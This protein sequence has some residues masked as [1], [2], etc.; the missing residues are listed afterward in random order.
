MLEVFAAGCCMLVFLY[1][2]HWVGA[3]WP[4]RHGWLFVS[5]DQL[6]VDVAWLNALVGLAA[7]VVARVLLAP[8]PAAALAVAAGLGLAAAS[9]RKMQLL[10]MPVLPWDLWFAADA[11]AF[12]GFLGWPLALLWAA[13]GLLALALAAVVWRWPAQL[14]RRRGHAPALLA[15]AGVVLAGNAWVV[16]PGSPRFLSGQVHNIGWDPGANHTNYG[17]FYAF[18]ANLK[19]LDL[20]VPDDAA[21]RAARGIG[22]QL[23]PA[24]AAVGK[25]PADVV[26]VLSE[27]FT[28]LPV[29]LFHQPWRCLDRAPAA[30]LLT[31]SWGGFTAN[32]EA[33]LLT[34]YPHALFPVGAVPYQMYL[35][36]PLPQA[37]PRVFRD[38]GYDT[39]ALHTFQR[40]FFARPTAYEMLGFAQYRGLEDLPPAPLRGQYVDDQ[41][42]FDELL[43]ALDA[44]GTQPRFLHAVTMMAHLP[45]DWPG[46]YAVPP[47]LQ[48][49]L[50][51]AL[52]AHR[53][54][55]TQ[56]AAMVYDHEA[57]LCRFLEQLK[58]RPRRT[59]VLFYGDHYPTFGTL[60][61]YRD[62]HRVLH[63][64]EPFDLARHY[65]RTPL[66][67]FDSRR[68]FVPLPAETPAYNVGSLLLRQAGLAAPGL[69]AM[70]HKRHNLA[71][72]PRRLYVA[73]H[74]NSA[75][76]GGTAAAP[77]PEFE[78]L[79]A[80]AH[81]ALFADEDDSDGED[82]ADTP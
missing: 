44:P 12:A 54:S 33:E 34:G 19:F 18:L 16:Q 45:Y 74:Q 4:L 11:A 80:H 13:A 71:V 73:A 32:V 36:R 38:A 60:D 7:Y 14:L 70:P 47:V 77:G 69:W 10:D 63:P 37:L 59:L 75:V 21:L 24:P 17:P 46:R 22:R 20:P 30:R 72:A 43:R 41:V 6:L 62:I 8:L 3:A 53:A 9:E 40:S 66:L 55:L 31:P 67:L 76:H 57:M 51:A 64:G 78:L 49:R 2:D 28:D 82:D 56:Y 29:R 79:Q 26:V 81:L 61:V 5:T 42:I 50:P 27:S 58:S 23:E 48:R 25:L 15:A 35:K 39:A 68:G 1:W 65:S 52:E